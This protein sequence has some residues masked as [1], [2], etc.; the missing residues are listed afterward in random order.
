MMSA[1]HAYISNI[2]IIVTS[3]FRSNMY[4]VFFH[5]YQYCKL[6]MAVYDA[7]LVQPESLGASSK[8]DPIT[9]RRKLK[10]LRYLFITFLIACLGLYQVKISLLDL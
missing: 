9:E 6:K 1:S 4:G 3:Y 2:S 7:D 10:S 5:R 8:Q